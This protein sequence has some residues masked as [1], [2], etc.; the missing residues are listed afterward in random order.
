MLLESEECDG[1]GKPASKAL[2][3]TAVVVCR[4]AVV[5]DRGWDERMKAVAKGG[6]GIGPMRE[7]KETK[8]FN[9]FFFVNKAEGLT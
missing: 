8:G 4:R 3:T 2:S 9:I 6:L 1:S 7:N 5:A